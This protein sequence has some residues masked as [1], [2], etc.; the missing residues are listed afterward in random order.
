MSATRSALHQRL[1]ALEAR[2]QTHRQI[3]LSRLSAATLAEVDA[4]TYPPDWS[5]L[6]TEA[7]SELVEAFHEQNPAG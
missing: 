2:Q 3:D 1:A 6:S 7:L 4:L 5:A